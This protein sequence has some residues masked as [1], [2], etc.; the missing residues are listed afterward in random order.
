VK[1]DCRNELVADPI[2]KR[3]VDAVLQC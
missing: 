2:R 3:E 1:K